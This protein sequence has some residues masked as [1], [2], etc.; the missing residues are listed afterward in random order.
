MTED[1]TRAPAPQLRR[2][3]LPL[4]GL[5]LLGAALVAL[6]LGGSRPVSS[7]DMKPDDVNE[8]RAIRPVP[9]PPGAAAAPGQPAAGLVEV[10]VN[11]SRAFPVQGL[12][13]VLR[14]GDREF[15]Y[16]R[17]AEGGTTH[18][19]I[20]Q[21]TPQEFD[22]TA[23]GEPVILYYGEQG[24]GPMAAPGAPAA[25]GVVPRPAGYVWEF[26]PLNK[27]LLK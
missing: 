20:F 23:N 7:Q 26:G 22:R 10:E 27:A 4:A 21:L 25:P 14:I 3:R 16:S 6:Q 9:P 8:I 2:M 5:A 17:Y 19:L 11:S 13:P 24:S 1:I 12:R 18:T 15:I